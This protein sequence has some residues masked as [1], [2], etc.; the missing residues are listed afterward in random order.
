MLRRLG[1]LEFGRFHLALC[2]GSLMGSPLA[3]LKKLDHKGFCLVIGPRGPSRP[4]DRGKKVES[5]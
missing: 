5:C 4:H 3:E 2:A 1:R